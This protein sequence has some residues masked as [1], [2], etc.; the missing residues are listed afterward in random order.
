M[1]RGLGGEVFHGQICHSPV[2]PLPWLFIGITLIVFA[3]VHLT[4]GS[5]IDEY[6]ARIR[7]SNRPI[8]K[9]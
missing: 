6:S 2:D 5:P 3:I 9:A 1:E 8:S 4:P 7:M